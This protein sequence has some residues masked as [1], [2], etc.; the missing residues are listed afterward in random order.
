MSKWINDSNNWWTDS[1]NKIS[2]LMSY[3]KYWGTNSLF[4]K[5]ENKGK[6]LHITLSFLYKLFLRMTNSWW[7]KLFFK[8]QLRERMKPE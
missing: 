3:V 5:T 7:E 2:L 1:N 8:K 6:E 4:W